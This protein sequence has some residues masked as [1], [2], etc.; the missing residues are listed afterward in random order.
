MLLRGTQS[1]EFK[2]TFW[3]FCATVARMEHLEHLNNMQKKAALHKDGPMLIIAGAGTGKTSTLTHRILN[4]I[5]E[6]VAP[7]NILAITFTNKA[8]KE[9]LER[10]D[11]LLEK[12]GFAAGVRD[13]DARPFI[14]TFHSLGVYIL[15]AHAHVFG[16]TRHFTILDKTNSLSL[17]KEAVKAQ[18]LDI[19]QF[20]PDRIAGVISRQKGNLMTASEYRRESGSTY[21]GGIVSSV[22]DRYEASLA[23]EQSLDF[24]DLLLKTVL[25]LRDHENVRKEYQKRWQYI[26]IDEY[27]DTNG[28][29]YELARLLAGDRMNICAVGDGDQNIYSWR[30]ANVQNI[31]NFEKDYNGAQTV[32]LEENYRSTQTI[33]AAANDVIKK[34]TIRKDKNLFTKND[35]GEKITLLQSYDENGEARTVG[36]R[37]KKLIDNGVKPEEIAVLYRANFQSRALEEG[38]LVME[39]PYQVLGVRFF[40]RKEV[41]DILSFIRAA[42]NPESFSDIKRIIDVPPRG[43]GKSTLIKMFAKDEASLAPAAKKRVAEFWQLLSSIREYASVEKTS[44]L[45]KFVSEKTGIEASLKTGS[46]E[47]NDRLENIHEMVTLATKYD[48]LPP[49]EA[50]ERLL[51]DAALASDQDSLIKSESAVKIMTVHAAKG[52]EFPYVFITG[53]EQDLFPHRKMSAGNVTK[54]DEEEER[55]LFYVAITRAKKK[56]FLS[57]ASVRTIFGKRQVNLPSEFLADIDDAYIELEAG[58]SEH[59]P[60]I[61]LDW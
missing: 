42:L 56:L 5:K 50:V 20:S 33:L 10:V 24:D 22:W 3:Q 19:K 18:G 7:Q 34:N 11:S 60:I 51:A 6:G 41:K 38:F 59:E 58:D 15:R 35:E 29:Q 4:L 45:I 14:G 31:L 61:R 52:L 28:V 32:L 57:Y 13:G 12:H 26:H 44:K 27:Q 8:A 17:I 37:I 43:I 48:F 9:M 46:D 16:L 23:R 30:G 39:I 55:R 21:F 40:E 49:E 1:T 53:L 25:L 47:D 2:N 36:D 54:E